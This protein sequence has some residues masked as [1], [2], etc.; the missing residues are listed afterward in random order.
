ML[1]QQDRVFRQ[2]PKKPQKKIKSVVEQKMVQIRQ[3]QCRSRIEI[4]KAL[5]FN[6]PASL[7]MLWFP[8]LTCSNVIRTVSPSWAAHI[9]SAAATEKSNGH[10]KFLQP[11][12]TAKT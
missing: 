5:Q 3:R 9:F 12:P 10:F 8:F 1:L 7:I 11:P 6:S 4:V 2:Q